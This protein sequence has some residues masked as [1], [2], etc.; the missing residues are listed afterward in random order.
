M[1]EDAE[2]DAAWEEMLTECLQ[3]EGKRDALR[4]TYYEQKDQEGKYYFFLEWASYLRKPEVMEQ[5]SKNEQS[6]GFNTEDEGM[7][8]RK[9]GS[10]GSDDVNSNASQFTDDDKYQKY[11]NMR[12]GTM[13]KS[14][15]TSSTIFQYFLLV[16]AISVSLYLFRYF[17]GWGSP[18]S[19][20]L[21]KVE[22]GDSVW[23]E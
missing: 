23:D 7:R 10:G 18:F 20:P 14:A 17:M 9:G 19:A 8:R 4:E 12:H 16:M 11:A 21:S 6:V 15:S 2:L 22:V 5:N 1:C 13:R 3:D